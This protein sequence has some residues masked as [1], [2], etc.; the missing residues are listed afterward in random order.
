VANLSP[1]DHSPPAL[2]RLLSNITS[3]AFSELIIAVARYEARLPLAVPL[4]G[5]LRTIHKV[6]R[7]K[8]VF[9]LERVGLPE[10]HRELTEA[11]VSATAEG[12]LDFLDSPP[13]IRISRRRHHKWD[14]L[15][16]D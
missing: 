9:S 14:F 8:L 2:V 12:L 11:L 1:V 10:V 3:P 13:T 5:R 15:D 7:F 4:F 16:F 6:R